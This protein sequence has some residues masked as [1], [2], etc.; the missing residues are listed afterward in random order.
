MNEPRDGLG[1]AGLQN[2]R[3]D[4]IRKGKWFQGALWK[5]SG[6]HWQPHIGGSRLRARSPE[7]SRLWN[8]FH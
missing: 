1:L 3:V 8:L 4:G 2:G 6:F 7:S 5:Q